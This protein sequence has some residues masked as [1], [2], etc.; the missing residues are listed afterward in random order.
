MANDLN[1][2][3]ACRKLTLN[4]LVTDA[5]EREDKKALPWL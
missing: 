4:D 2:F 3:E 5:V 1:S